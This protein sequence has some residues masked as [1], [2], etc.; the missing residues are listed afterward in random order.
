MKFFHS[1]KTAGV[2]P[3]KIEDV[4]PI[5][6]TPGDTIIVSWHEPGAPERE[7][8]RET[9]DRTLVVDRIVIVDVKD[10]FGLED[11]IGALLGKKQL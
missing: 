5:Y 8:A 11:G 2:R 6:V 10:A 9:V 3:R 4:A 1:W 7:V